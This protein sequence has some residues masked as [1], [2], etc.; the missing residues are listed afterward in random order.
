[1]QL[2]PP[3]NLDEPT[4]SP[5]E[6]FAHQLADQ[7]TVARAYEKNALLSYALLRWSES[8]HEAYRYF[9]TSASKEPAV[10]RAGEW[11]LDNFYIVEETLRQIKED[12]PVSYYDQ[13]PKLA[14]T[15]LKHYPRVFAL[16]SELAAY[17]QCR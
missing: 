4:R 3:I 12:L 5:L 7:H 6:R 13:L 8:L 17:S 14:G 9:R 11:M 16:A 15:S 1:M 2:A 10:T